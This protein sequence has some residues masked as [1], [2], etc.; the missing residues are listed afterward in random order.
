MV[1]ITRL[2]GGGQIDRE[3]KLRFLFNGQRYEGRPGDTLASALLAN[4]VTLIGRS[5]KFHRPRGVL[6]AGMEEPAV[7]L[8]VGVGPRLMPTMKPTEV[9]LYDGL[10]ARSSHC[11][12][13][14]SF[15]LAAV[16]G[17]L[18]SLLAAGFPH[19][20]FKAPGGVW[21]RIYEPALRWAAGWAEA[22]D[23]AD[24]DRY[25]HTHAH[26]D[27]LVV[28]AGEA[29][30]TAAKQAAEQG[31]RVVILEQDSL[32]GGALLRKAAG[33][34]RTARWAAQAWD[35][36][37]ALPEVTPCLRTA[38]VGVYDQ[39]L[40][41]AVER[42]TDHR[43]PQIGSATPRQRLWKIRAKRILL[44]TGRIE[45]PLVFPG[46]DRP[47]VLL[48]GA[49]A[50]YIR[51]WA[52]LPGQKVAIAACEDSAYDAALAV[53][54]AGGRVVVI[55]D[56][57]P[58]DQLRN[59]IVDSVRRRGVEIVPAT[60]VDSSHG[61]RRVH[62]VCLRALH[63]GGLR[64][65]PCDL[66]AI[67]GGWAPDLALWRQAG[68]TVQWDERLA[69]L[70]PLS[71]DSAA[72]QVIGCARGW[73]EDDGG[74]G[75]LQAL[76]PMADASASN[77]GR[78]AAFVDLQGDVTVADLH[79]A[80]REGFESVEHIKRYTGL[81][82]GTDQ[83]RTASLNA[84]RL[85]SLIRKQPPG[86]VGQTSARPPAYPVALGV[87]AGARTGALLAPRRLSP[88]DHW[89]QARGARWCDQG[90]WRMP[91]CY[92]LAGESERQAIE[93]EC[94]AARERVTLFDVSSL[95]K[96]DLQ[97]CDAAEFLSQIYT[98]PV[99]S[100]GVGRVRYSLMLNER[101]AV[102]T[103]GTVTR[104]AAD[105]YLLTVPAAE[106]EAVM[107]HLTYWHQVVHAHLDLY[108]TDVTEQWATM[109]LGGPFARDV[110]ARLAPDVYLGARAFPLM[111]CQDAAVAGMPARVTRT[112]FTG[113]LTFEISVP[114]RRALSLWYVILERGSVHGLLPIGNGSI[115]VLRAEK[116][117]IL[118]D[119]EV[120]G[121]V[122]PDD[123]G[124]GRL[125]ATGEHDYVGKR[126][127]ALPA[128]RG[129]EGPRRQLV[130][131]LTED[132][133]VVLPVGAQVTPV[134]GAVAPMPGLGHVTSGY[135]SPTLGR[136]IALALVE[137]GRDLHGCMVHLPLD[138]GRWVSAQVTSPHFFDPTGRRRDG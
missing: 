24:R 87:L 136:S 124:L 58:A 3:H 63:G 99:D 120:D 47:G 32:P 39:G 18:G 44:A 127:L 33:D 10:I 56:A 64:R 29:G 57:R 38:A 49:L 34:G 5:L 101:G 26:A 23:E 6:S 17:W 91:A 81:G 80:L 36:L 129:A 107:N 77:W 31:L 85:L 90:A 84:L 53:L 75:A 96:I 9:E 128:L 16:N 7:L 102:L 105:H 106:T 20:M 69:A 135:Y 13:S 112:S 19:K 40:V 100:L 82:M 83:G 123:L 43:G 11:W 51:R 111:S 93:R 2:P 97:G 27:L 113:E 8:S 76:A 60:T 25:D 74:C 67:G 104:L 71:K 108:I 133:Q 61:R 41:V 98:Q 130:G 12:P 59:P 115:D 54:D 21:Q 89:H 72:V 116:G 15:D 132:P 70:V 48:T 117:F 103:D 118:L 94:R 35:E 109:A 22:P 78:R 42:C 46:N 66:L 68:G 114:A 86:D 28:G 119:H 30:L 95:G 62:S 55:A 126:A 121:A 52:V 110:M 134:R 137:A 122:T 88:I 125:L 65:L 138:Q 1:E 92:P 50:A 131:L 37:A 79:L 73:A 45:Q 14:P 4:G